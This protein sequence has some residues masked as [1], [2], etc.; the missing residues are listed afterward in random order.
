MEAVA[1]KAGDPDWAP[2]PWSPPAGLGPMPADLEPR[3]LEA[4]EA[5]KS[6]LARVLEARR[7]VVK[8]ITALKAVP[9]KR[10]KDASVYLD[11]SA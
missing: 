6:A 4:Q 1:G 9:P 7:R 10:D 5:Q 11:A 2:S 3:A 8:H